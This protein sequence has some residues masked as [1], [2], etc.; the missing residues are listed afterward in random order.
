MYRYSKE[1]DDFVPTDSIVGR[2]YSLIHIGFYS[3]SVD[4]L[5][6]IEFIL[7][8]LINGQKNTGP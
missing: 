5:V 7:I 1:E 3:G 2:M 8:K 4:Y 6:L